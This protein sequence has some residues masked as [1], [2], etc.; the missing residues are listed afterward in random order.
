MPRKQRE[1]FSLLLS[2]AYNSAVVLHT[3]REKCLGLSDD[4]CYMNL[5]LRHEG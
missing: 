4:V 1:V 5:V 3:K 2:Q